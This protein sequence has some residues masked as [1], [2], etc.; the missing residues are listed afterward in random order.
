LDVKYLGQLSQFVRSYTAFA[1]LDARQRCCV[2]VV[3]SI[4]GLY[5]IG[6]VLK[7][8]ST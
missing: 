7:C 4:R 2:E 6:Y 8:E 1:T 5:S 3:Y